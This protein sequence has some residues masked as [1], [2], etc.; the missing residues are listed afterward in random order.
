MTSMKKRFSDLLRLL[1]PA[2]QIGGLEITDSAIRFLQIKKEGF[3]TASIKLPPGVI[4]SGK[5][6]E[7]QRPNLVA[8]LKTVHSQ[9]SA[10]NK[11]MINIVLTMPSSNVYIQSF[12]VS[13]LA[14]ENLIEAADLNLRMLSPIPIETSYF[15]WQKI[16]ESETG[17]GAIE[18]LGA[19][20]P[21]V[22]IDDIIS[23]LHESGFGVAAV[24]F[25][26]LSLVR[27]LREVKAVEKT[28]PYLV[29]HVTAEGLDFIVVRNNNLYF[30]YF[31]PWSLVQGDGRNIS[32]QNLKETIETEVGKVFNFYLGHWGGQIKN[33]LLITPAL[34]DELKSILGEKF[35]S[36]Q[37]TIIDSGEVTVVGGTALRGK[38][39]MS[40]DFDISLTSET[41]AK[42]FEEEQMLRFVAIWRNILF[43][44]A[45][46][47]LLTFAATQI[48]LSRSADKITE[49]GSSSVISH[50]EEA[51]LK[52]LED[53]AKQFNK[54]VEL[55]VAA[56]ESSKEISPF[57]IHLNNLAGNKISFDRIYLQAFD[58][59]ATISG[60][61]PSEEAILEFKRALEL[62][63]Q[64]AD[65]S[66]PLSSIITK[67]SG[68]LAFTISFL[69]KSFNFPIEKST[70]DQELQETKKKNEATLGEQLVGVTEA[71]KSAKPAAK[72]PLITF[73][74]L[75]FKSISDP[76]TLEVSAFDEETANLFR[77]KLEDSPNFYNVQIVSGMTKTDDGR[78]K[79][80]IRFSVSL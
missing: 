45:S 68:Q 17:G 10:D 51:E 34:H 33:I 31:Y 5:V 24:E 60:S 71:L 78:V 76:A 35:P 58:R 27:H 30:D 49:T 23:A 47:I 54:L 21:A 18:L 3:I 39:S 6:M 20:A 73:G 66:L 65:V 28:L 61:A 57:L 72:E 44:V 12:N 11:K 1:S 38:L 75:E 67:P 53:K 16:G 7:G 43:T 2:P 59:P 13:K 8:A 79:F 77:D 46:F 15:G 29:I 19:F 64:L 40:E 26:S 25:A 56:M 62:Q 42:I 63:P 69:I 32:V 52:K 37:L 36:L 80:S 41:A 70:V 48:Y 9:L 50:T 74:R 14:E 22:N 4:E 55:V